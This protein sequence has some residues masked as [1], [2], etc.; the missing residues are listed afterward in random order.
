MLPVLSPVPLS[1]EGSYHSR[2]FAPATAG[3]Q[4]VSSWSSGGLSHDTI[5]ANSL[6]KRLV[7][8]C[9]S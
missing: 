5:R 7:S 8:R 6:H 3:Q 9:R 4:R 2:P 1:E